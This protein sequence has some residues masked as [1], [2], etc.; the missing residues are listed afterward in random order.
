MGF[1]YEHDANWFGHNGSL[2]WNGSIAYRSETNQFEI[3]SQFLDQP[4]YSLVNMSLVWRTVDGKYEWGLHGQNLTDK[5]Y[6]VA[7]YNFATP[8]GTVPTLGLEGVV[9]AFY[10]PPRTIS[11][12]FKMH[13]E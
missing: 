1:K 13:F 5:E 2:S 3:P 4:G 6:I 10:G 11:A 9:S 8:D 12:T 7:G